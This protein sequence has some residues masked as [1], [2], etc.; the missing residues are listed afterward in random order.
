MGEF[1]GSNENCTQPVLFQVNKEY[2]TPQSAM[3]Y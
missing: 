3:F 2:V 1:N